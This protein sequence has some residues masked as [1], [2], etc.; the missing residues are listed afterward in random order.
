MADRLLES[1]IRFT[2]KLKKGM[3]AVLPQ[4][5]TEITAIIAENSR[6]IKKIEQI[7]DILLDYRQM[8]VGEKEFRRLNGYYAL[9]N[10]DN[11]RFYA[12]AYDEE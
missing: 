4:I 7:L 10:A 1:I 8:G 12:D 2:D 6:D 5:S 9:F 3:E 11:A